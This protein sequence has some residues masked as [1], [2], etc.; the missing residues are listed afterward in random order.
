MLFKNINNIIKIFIVI[1]SNLK[2]TLNK[3][4]YCKE[5]AV[6]DIIAP[7]VVAKTRKNVLISFEGH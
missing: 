6:K 7:N 1:A 5:T 2:S 3:C 4:L